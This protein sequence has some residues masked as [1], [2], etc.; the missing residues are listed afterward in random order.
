MKG[1]AITSLVLALAL[2]T[3]ACG[4]SEQEKQADEAKKQIEQ[5]QQQIA[6]A[7]RKAQQ[8]GAEAG[9]QA[10]QAAAEAGRAAGAAGA[11]AGAE[12]AKGGAAA[13]NEAANGL[14]ALAKGLSSLAATGPDGKPVEPVNFHDL[15]AA[16]VPLDGWDMGKPTGSKMAMPVSFSQAEVIYRKGDARITASIT[17]SGFNQLVFA[18]FS[19]L[20]VS[21]YEKETENGFEKSTKVAGNPGW[22]K[23]DG[24]EKTGEVAAFVNKR[25]VVNFKGRGIADNKVLYQLAESSNLGKLAS[26]K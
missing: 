9:R 19:A 15:Q 24:Q 14:A 8:A 4:K 11:V 22:E 25:F 21:G 6:E 18:P 17:D 3:T 5:A 20:L 7:A 12:A 1:R 2:A 26:L 23:W 10:G 16:F 13:A